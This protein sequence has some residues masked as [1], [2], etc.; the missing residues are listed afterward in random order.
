[1]LFSMILFKLLKLVKLDRKEQAK[2]WFFLVVL[3]YYQYGYVPIG[4]NFPDMQAA[5]IK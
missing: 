3:L 2:I 5:K 1:M 4:S